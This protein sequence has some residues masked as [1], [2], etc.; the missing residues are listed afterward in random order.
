MV[1][2]ALFS[3]I[4]QGLA[5]TRGVFSGV[6]SLFRL[7]GRVDEDF[8]KELEKQKRK[9]PADQLHLLRA[10]EVLEHIGTPEARQAL[11]GLE[12]LQAGRVD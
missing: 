3:K 5:K 10:V 1:F 9:V 11:E 7:K 6:A 12:T 2:R 4:K 8:L